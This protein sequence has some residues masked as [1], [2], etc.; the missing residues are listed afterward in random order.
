[1]YR[2]DLLWH[3]FRICQV[4]GGAA[5]VD[6]QTF[7]DIEEYGTKKWLVELAEELR[8]HRYHPE[9]V[10]RVHIPKAGK[11]G[12]TRPLGIPTIRTRV[13]MT[14]AMLVLEPIFETDT[15]PEQYAYRQKRSALDAVQ[16]IRSLLK[17]RHWDVLDADLS[18]YF[19]SIPHSELFKSVARRISD[20][21]V[22]RLIKMWLQAPVEETDRRGR[23]CRTTWNKDK[24]RGTPQGAPI[25]PLLKD[26]AARHAMMSRCIAITSPYEISSRARAWSWG[27][28][29]RP[30]RNNSHA[31]YNQKCRHRLFRFRQTSAGRW[32]I[33]WPIAGEVLAVTHF[34]LLAPLVSKARF[35]TKLRD[36]IN[37]LV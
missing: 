32:Q 4:N 19:D 15:Q 3:A 31:R 27:A 37:D 26:A 16:Y 34:S 20:R 28:R 36:K 11:P 7:E 25:S 10:R 5:G 22:L 1:M 6:G 35:P 29:H 12:A 33:N 30:H 14:A 18:G 13:V 17:S 24:G 2:A 8:T 21:Y 23:K 9:P